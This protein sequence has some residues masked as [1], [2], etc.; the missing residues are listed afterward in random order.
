M[1]LIT[2]PSEPLQQLMATPGASLNQTMVRLEGTEKNEDLDKQIKETTTKKYGLLT[3]VMA[4]ML[5]DLACVP[6]IDA[7]KLEEWR[8]SPKFGV[9]TARNEIV[10]EAVEICEEQ[11]ETMPIMDWFN[12]LSDSDRNPRFNINVRYMNEEKSKDVLKK[13]FIYQFGS[14]WKEVL[15]K[16]YA[17]S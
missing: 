6:L 3:E 15:K 7:C 11:T 9:F 4:N 12:H 8:S 16:I 1:L 10:K 13:W 17:V 14:V 5:L 2:Q